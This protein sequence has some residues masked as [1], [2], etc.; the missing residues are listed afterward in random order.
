MDDVR[1]LVR[2]LSLHGPLS[3]G[4]LLLRTY[5]MNDVKGWMVGQDTIRVWS[6]DS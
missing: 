2:R 5:V 1:M 4:G 6:T 3:R